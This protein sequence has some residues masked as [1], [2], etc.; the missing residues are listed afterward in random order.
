MNK[1]SLEHLNVFHGKWLTSGTQHQGPLGDAAKITAVE[2]YE[3]LP[4]ERFLIH[5]FDGRVGDNPAACIEVIGRDA[6]DDDYPVNTFYNNGVANQWRLN[7]RDGSWL[8][9]GKWDAGGEPADVRCTTVFSD[10]GCAMAGKWEYSR[11]GSNW[12]TFWEV[13]ARKQT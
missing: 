13:D 7:E 10:D 11:D 6:A 4:G 1:T 5:R 12:E 2:T 9:T 3:W 8:L